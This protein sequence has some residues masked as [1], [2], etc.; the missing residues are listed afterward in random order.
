MP[1]HASPYL[2]QI[3]PVPPRIPPAAGADRD[4]KEARFNIS[5]KADGLGE[6]R[7]RPSNAELNLQAFHDDV[8]GFRIVNCR[9]TT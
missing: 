2:P 1:L 4:R 5:P 9:S 7:D 8:N 6:T 3:Q